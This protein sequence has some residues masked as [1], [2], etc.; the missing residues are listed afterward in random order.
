MKGGRRKRIVTVTQP[1]PPSKR[2]MKR[3]CYLLSG[4]LPVLRT[5]ARWI[6]K[7]A[8]QSKGQVVS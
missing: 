8:D 3:W 4:S 5:F 7:L 6:V 2:V 1:R